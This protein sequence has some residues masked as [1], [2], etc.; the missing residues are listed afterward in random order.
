[1]AAYTI[2]KLKGDNMKIDRIKKAAALILILLFFSSATFSVTARFYSNMPPNKPQKPEGPTGGGIIFNRVLV[3][4]S[5]TYSTA[6]ADPN[7][8]D[9]YYKWDWGDGNQSEWDGPWASGMGVEG[10]YAWAE[11]G[12]YQ[13]KVMAKD[14]LGATSVWSQLLNVTVRNRFSLVNMDL[15]VVGSSQMYPS[16][17]LIKNCL[18][19]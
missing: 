5:Y 16:S 6:T 1:M 2:K 10:S 8:D 14:S 12:V 15:M 11:P 17:T 9:V 19:T 3:G 4:N 13:V 7:G 18:Y